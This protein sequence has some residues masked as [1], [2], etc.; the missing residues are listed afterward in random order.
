[1]IAERRASRSSGRFVLSGFVVAA[2]L[3]LWTVRGVSSVRQLALMLVLSYVLFW[4]LILLLWRMPATMLA[5]RFGLSTF[6]ACVIWLAWRP[7]R[8]PDSSNIAYCSALPSPTGGTAH[9]TMLSTASCSVST[10][11]I[12]A[13]PGHNQATSPLLCDLPGLQAIF[14]PT[15][16]PSRF[17]G[18][19]T[20]Q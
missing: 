10:D 1:M 9:P 17:W 3:S 13:S 16:P 20:G 12:C 5:A 15:V 2:W 8:C 18:L 6:G 14:A 19:Q 7:P 11:R 4:G